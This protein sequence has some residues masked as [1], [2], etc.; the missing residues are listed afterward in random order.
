MRRLILLFCLL[1][2]VISATDALAMKNSSPQ[3]AIVIA[4]FGTTYPNA[5]DAL[6]AIVRDVEVRYPDT[7]VQMAFTSNIIRKK[8]HGRAADLTYHKAHPEVPD[9][10]YRIKNLLGTLADLQDT[11][12]KTVVV[13]PTLLTHGE[14][15]LDTQAYVDGLLSIQTVKDHWRPFEKIALGRPLMGTWGDEH[16]YA[17][18]LEK[19]AEALAPD[20]E[21]AQAAGATL[22]Y[23]GH[24]NEH[25]STG[26]YYEL[27]EAMNRRYPQTTTVVGLVEGHPEFAEVLKKLQQ[28]DTKK[29]LLKPLMVVAGN[30]ASIDMAGEE[31]VSWK[32]QL[33]AAGF[34][35]QTIM[36]GLG[37]NS[38]VRQMFL[39]HLQDAAAEA[40]IELR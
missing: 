18:D 37:D 20:I 30:H 4:A 33:T 40:G 14:E 16:P 7:E 23:M 5:V 32:S 31:A 39:N 26:L 10:F 11:G 21:Q 9:Y 22:V 29:I 12:F 27:E 35:V 15:Y 38:A 1:T 19:L 2:L 6:L 8:W 36:Q 34:K 28:D 24:G 25:L 13:Q 17:E 3:T